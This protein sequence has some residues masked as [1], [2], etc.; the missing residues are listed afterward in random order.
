MDSLHVLKSQIYEY[1]NSKNLIFNIL[2]KDNSLTIYLTEFQNN[3]HLDFKNNLW[4]IFILF[5]D[6]T[7]ENLSFIEVFS[8]LENIVY[9]IN[10]MFHPLKKEQLFK[11]LE[12]KKSLINL[13]QQ[14]DFFKII[15]EIN[16]ENFKINIKLKH[17]YFKKSE[18]I[19]AYIIQTDLWSFKG[20][21][22][23]YE[24]SIIDEYFQLFQEINNLINVLNQSSSTLFL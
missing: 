6:N 15:D 2:E 16:I 17:T 7:Y 8:D 9:D 14:H 11:F 19:L 10:N 20:I 13:L 1:L 22:I 3:I 24:D 12:E 23:F 21:N 18:M 4:N 5:E